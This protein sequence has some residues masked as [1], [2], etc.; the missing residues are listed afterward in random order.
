MSP[1]TFCDYNGHKYVVAEQLKRYLEYACRRQKY[2]V[3]G[4]PASD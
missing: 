1:C 3:K 4:I 2:N